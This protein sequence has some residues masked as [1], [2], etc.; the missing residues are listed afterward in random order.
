MET[1]TLLMI[2]INDV[3]NDMNIRLSFIKGLY[4]EYKYHLLSKIKFKYRII[5]LLRMIQLKYI[6]YEEL[7]C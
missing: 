4:T 2:N 5:A 1:Y 3:L 7:K 6:F